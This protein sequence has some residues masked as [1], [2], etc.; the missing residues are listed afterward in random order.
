MFIACGQCHTCSLTP[1][2]KLKSSSLRYVLVIQFKKPAEYSDYHLDHCKYIYHCKKNLVILTTVL[3]IS[4]A[5]MPGGDSY[6]ILCFTMS[7]EIIL[8]LLAFP[9]K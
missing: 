6:N 4:V 8:L 1:T 5:D 9:L 2:C 3:A 7:K